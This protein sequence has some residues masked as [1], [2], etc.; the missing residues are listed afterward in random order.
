MRKKKYFSFDLGLV[1]ALISLGFELLELDKTNPK[2]VKFIFEESEE[3]NEAVAAYW[4]DN[5]PINARS[6][7]D[8]LKMA[9]NRIYSD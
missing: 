6:L 1:T 8:N 4:S 9:K 7:F 2:K 3:L 5:L